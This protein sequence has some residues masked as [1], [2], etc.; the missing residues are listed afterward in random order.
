MRAGPLPA[1]PEPHLRGH[2]LP[3]S[4]L[5]A[6]VR[7]LCLPSGL[8]TCRP[9]AF[10]Q[11]IT[12][13]AP[14]LSP[15]AAMG[16]RRAQLACRSVGCGSHVCQC[17]SCQAGGDSPGVCGLLRQGEWAGSC[18]H[19]VGRNSERTVFVQLMAPSSRCGVGWG[20]G[21]VQ[22]ALRSEDTEQF[23]P[24][25]VP[26]PPPLRNTEE[27][28]TVTGGKPTWFPLGLVGV[29]P[30]PRG[31]V[32]LTETQERKFPLSL[33]RENPKLLRL[34]GVG[35][36]PEL[37][38]CRRD[39][40]PAP[41]SWVPA[42]AAGSLRWRLGQAPRELLTALVQGRV[43]AACLVLHTPKMQRQEEAREGRPPTPSLA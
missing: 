7:P 37:Q 6:G 15:P 35:P 26:S 2:L 32:N 19:G 30:G 10:P 16:N 23:H 13:T 5:P 12:A 11:S 43:P 21:A 42:W 4:G 9:A 40:H 3:G 1:R 17:G 18:G 8:C 38:L 22:Q 33:R 27:A 28:A 20:W 14:P 39:G 29:G 41:P 31:K 34:G 24:E 25:T 36:S